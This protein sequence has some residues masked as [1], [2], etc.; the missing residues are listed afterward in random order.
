MQNASAKA[1]D[2]VGYL[3]KEHD[4]RINSFNVQVTCATG[5]TGALAACSRR[6]RGELAYARL[7]QKNAS[8]KCSVAALLE[9]P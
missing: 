9:F 4:L 3:V 7:A 6:G 8:G 2:T 5:Y 1:K